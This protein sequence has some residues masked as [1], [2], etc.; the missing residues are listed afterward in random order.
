MLRDYLTL[1]F[2]QRPYQSGFQ[3]LTT[4]RF[5][6]LIRL[7]HHVGVRGTAGLERRRG[8]EAFVHLVQ[9]FADHFTDLSLFCDLLCFF[10]HLPAILEQV[11]PHRVGSLKRVKGARFSK[12]DLVFTYKGKI[13]AHGLLSD[14]EFISDLGF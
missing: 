7:V 10:R 1:I 8:E 12:L 2:G 11:T 3:L 13:V 4:N 9:Y 6:F 5:R 14:V